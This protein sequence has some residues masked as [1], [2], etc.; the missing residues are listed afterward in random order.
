VTLETFTAWKEKRKLEKQ[1]EAEEALVKSQVNADAKRKMMKGKNSVMNGRA[2]FSY[3]PD[4]FKDDEN[5]LEQ[6]PEEEVDQDLFAQE[7][8]KEEDDVDFD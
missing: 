2:L 6:L 3:N 4:M 7:E 1:Q 8:V 5:A